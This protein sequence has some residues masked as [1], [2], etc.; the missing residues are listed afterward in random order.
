LDT[1]ISFEIY[2]DWAGVDSGSIV[3]T[4]SGLDNDYFAVYSGSDLNFSGLIS[5]A[6]TPDYLVEL[7][8][9]DFPVGVEIS[10]SVYA[11]DNENH[12]GIL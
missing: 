11:K 3:V 9:D 4:L 10:V 6:N 5:A 2:D 7:V 1:N 12:G 8:H